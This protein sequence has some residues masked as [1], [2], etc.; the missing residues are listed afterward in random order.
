MQKEYLAS[1]EEVLEEQSSNAETGLSASVAQQRLA[2]VGPNKLDEEEKTP[3]W[4][5]FFQQMAD[6]MVIMLIVAAVISAVT[7]M[8]QGESEWADV[9]I[10]M[11][12]VIINSALG[13]IQEAKSEEALAALQE[14]SAAQSKVIRDGKLVM[15]HSSELVPGDIILLEAGDSVPADCR[16]LESASMKIEEAALTGESVPVEKH[17]EP[18]KLEAGADDVPLGDRKNMCYMG[19]TVVYGRGRAVVVDTGMKT[20]MG[21][22]AGALNDAKEELTPLQMK[23][24]ELSKI[25]TIMVI[26]ICVVIFAVDLLRSGLGNVMAEP[27]MLLDTFMVA[28]SLAVAAIPEGLVAVVTIV[29]SIGVTKMAKRQAIIR[30]LSAVETLGC[31]QVICSDK[32]G[33]LTQNK[34]T[35]VKH[36]LA[37][38]EEKL[39]AGMALCSDAKW[40]AEAGEAKGEPTECALVNDAAKAGMTG[41]DVEHPRV[42]EAPFDSGRKMMSVVVQE[43]DGSFEQY[44]KGAP[45]VVLNL[46]TQVYENGEIVPMTDAK[47]EQLLAA[48]KA[49]ADEALR[50]LA[51]ASRTYSAKPADCSPEALENNLVF[52]GLSGM[53]DPERPEV[54]PAIEE[55]HGAGIRT[56][57]ITGDHIDTAVAIAKN[58]GIVTD[59]S[60][61]I[62]GAEIDK[63]SDAELD[64][65]I[66]KYGVYARV[67]PEHKTR[68][69]EA[70]KSKNKVVAMTGDGVNDAPSIKHANIGIG[71]GI[72][73]T[74]VTKNVADMVLAD[75]NFA[76]IIGACEEGR[77]IY[78]NIRKVIQFLLSANLA[79]VFSVFTATIIGFTLFQPIQLLWV[80][81]VTDCFPALALGMEEA[82]GDIMKRKPRKASDGVFAGG[83]GVDILFQGIVITILVLASFFVGVYLD[84][85]YI[86]IADMIAG[87]ADEEGVTMAF[88]TLSMVEIFHCFNMRSRRASLFSM[89]KQN[90]WLW[91]AAILAL[92][93]TVIVVEVPFLAEMFGFMELP[94]EALAAALGLA[95]LI[96]PIM[97]IYKAVMRGIEKNQG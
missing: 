66:E 63:M 46:C 67:Q 36:E 22:I 83:M 80:N 85:G 55:A 45:D 41:L 76:T 9:V 21:K 93:L 97:E 73:G 58:L 20:E 5:R 49:M 13:V 92:I 52:C 88:I 8:I 19:S 43:D 60:Q 81:L 57:M 64:A 3:L 40:D 79:E 4:I 17:T 26:V 29:L 35:V 48:N 15:L 47:R 7:G 89:K 24:A 87:T 51:L 74:D 11:A 62:T 78:D 56:V 2:E 53:I 95:F 54:A 23:L 28:V 34:M 96:I 44:T 86:N 25:L 27:H 12:V 65:N 75:D 50:V 39:L 14:M 68:I 77:R 90:K 71:M 16:V 33:T 37:S 61:A 31:T 38:S 72:T 82:E 70:W 6:P 91:G 94:M 59:R 42:G 1:A 10:I 84:M 30:N 69:V 32:T 18:I